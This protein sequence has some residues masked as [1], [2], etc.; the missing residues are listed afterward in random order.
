MRI[1]DVDNYRSRIDAVYGTIALDFVGAQMDSGQIRGKDVLS[2]VEMRDS[3]NILLHREPVTN[4]LFNK[5]LDLRRKN[6]A[7]SHGNYIPSLS[8]AEKVMS[9][10]ENNKNCALLLL[11]LSDG[12]PSDT[13]HTDV[14]WAVQKRVLSLYATF[15][16]R[17][18]IGTIGFAQNTDFSVLE[19]MAN[20]PKK[21]DLKGCTGIFYKSDLCARAL[22]NAISQLTTKLSATRTTLT[23]TAAKGPLKDY[24]KEE[25]SMDLKKLSPNDWDFFTERLSR[26]RWSPTEKDWIYNY[27][28]VAKGAS[29]LVVSF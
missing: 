8:L 22:G 11:F 21:F 14:N 6:R 25:Y 16:S 20:A 9:R 24:K 19:A 18:T 27:S 23:L 17:L 28:L 3:G 12:K 2:L 15:G 4:V 10:D 26:A 1:S 13:G 7:Y 5:I 29:C